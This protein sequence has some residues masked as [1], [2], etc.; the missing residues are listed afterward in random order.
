[1]WG[2]VRRGELPM[3][4]DDDEASKYELADQLLKD[5]GYNW[6]RNF[7][8]GSPRLTSAATTK[9]TGAKTRSGGD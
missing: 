7:Q 1:M 8:L 2:Q 9:P 3:P 4:S 5:A 6:Y